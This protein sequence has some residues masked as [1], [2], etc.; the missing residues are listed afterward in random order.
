MAARQAAA[1]GSDSR[2][3][4]EQCSGALVGHLRPLKPFPPMQEPIVRLT[5]QLRAAR[6]VVFFTGAGISTESGI[7]DFRSPGGLWSRV[8]PIEFQDFMNSKDMR[9]ESWRRK[10]VTDRTM[11]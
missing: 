9:R 8:P 11:R 1:G 2:R 10:L 6:R 5:E 3:F 7:P 4:R